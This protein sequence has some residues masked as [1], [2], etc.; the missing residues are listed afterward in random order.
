MRYRFT[1]Q[2]PVTFTYNWH[3]GDGCCDDYDTDYEMFSEGDEIDIC[4]GVYEN[5]V[6]LETFKFKENYPWREE[7]AHPRVEQWQLY[8]LLDEGVLVAQPISDCQD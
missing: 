1:R 3:C 6:V 7:D 5:E 2:Y 8:E 4:S